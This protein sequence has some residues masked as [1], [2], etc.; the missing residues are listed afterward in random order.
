[1]FIDKVEEKNDTE[2][3]HYKCPNPECKNYGYN[4]ETK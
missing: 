1:M 4:K 3:F 2:V